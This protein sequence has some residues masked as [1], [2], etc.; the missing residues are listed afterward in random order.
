MIF[1]R[2]FATCVKAG[3]SLATALHHLSSE[4]SNGHL[5][6]A[7]RKAQICV[8]RGG[9]LS[10]WMKTRPAIFTGTECAL[11]FVGE[12]SGSL[13]KVLDRI[14]NDL[15][16]ETNLHRRLF[17]ATFL[18]KYCVLPMLLIVPGT[19]NI[20]MHGMD[21]LEKAGAGIS[22][23]AQQEIMLREGLRGYFH[24]LVARLVPLAIAAV[25]C[26]V[27]YRVL[28]RLPIGRYVRD[29]AVLWLP[30]MGP[31]QR[32]IIISRY[33]T[34]LSL[35]TGAGVPAAAALEACT[36][37][38]NNAVLDAKF[39]AAARLAREKNASITE[40]LT[41][42][43]VL[44]AVTLSLLRTGDVSGA[45]PEMLNRAAEFYESNVRTRLVSVPKIVSAVCLTACGI[46]TAIVVGN[47]A[48]LYFD[49]VFTAVD[50]F[51]D[52]K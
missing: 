34:A 5:R 15:E 18:A 33:L 29:Q 39:D 32:D 50:R 9:R 6:E 48:K 47:A 25:L 36:G 37:M 35:L 14:A 40:A 30:G 51:M 23:K 1:F 26:Y 46:A 22:E 4:T 43:G 3:M 49:N 52:I 27:A 16:D 12:T 7:A 17:L 10:A 38:A 42:T 21:S 41:S 45:A 11:I 13:D 2:Q 19:A 28:I 44:S 20:M 24:D 8:E 31:L